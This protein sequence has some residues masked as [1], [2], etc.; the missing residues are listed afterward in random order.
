M[1]GV[2]T[3]ALPILRRAI[4]TLDKVGA[5]KSVRGRG[6]FVTSSQKAGEFLGD[7]T[8]VHGSEETIGEIM[9]SIKKQKQELDHALEFLD[10]LEELSHK[11]YYA[12][13]FSPQEVTIDEDC[14]CK[15]KTFGELQIWNESGATVIA[16]K[17]G[18][19]YI[20][21]PGPLARIEMGDVLYFI[22]KEGA[23]EKL[24]RMLWPK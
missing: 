7:Y 13:P 2:Q 10:K 16:V 14:V 18:D 6:V 15:G 19:D 11:T 20:I 9:E 8:D 23:G 22:G 3:C 4:K 1:T 12:F 21:S 5:V 17:H 24:I